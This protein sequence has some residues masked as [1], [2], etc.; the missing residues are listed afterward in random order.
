MC[1]SML[2]VI[3]RAQV[4]DVANVPPRNKARVSL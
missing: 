4:G 3:A 2:L 1:A